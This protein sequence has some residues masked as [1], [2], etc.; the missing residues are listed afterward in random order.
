MVMILLRM[1][2]KMELLFYRSKKYK[3]KNYIKVK[4]SFTFLN[5]LAILKRKIL[6]AKIIAITGSA[7]KTSLKTILGKILSDYGNTYYSPKSYNNHYGVPLSLCNLEINHKY[8]V[9]EIG[10]NKPGEIEKLS[11]IVKQKISVITNIAE[12]HIENFK[13]L[14]GIAK[15]KSQIISNTE[16]NGTVILNRDDKFFSF[17][18]EKAKKKEFKSSLFWKT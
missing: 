15:E 4:N 9:F 1:Q 7:G 2:K 17:L 13:N 5:K 11:K 16:K 14:F 8:G 12:A 10:M 3:I 18:N 6:S